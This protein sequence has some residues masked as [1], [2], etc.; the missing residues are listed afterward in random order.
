MILSLKGLS[1]KY[2]KISS[3][4]VCYYLEEM[5]IPY[6]KSIYIFVRI[7]NWKQLHG[8]K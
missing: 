7:L 1:C 8:H 5:H 4:E 6:N 2:E 3:R